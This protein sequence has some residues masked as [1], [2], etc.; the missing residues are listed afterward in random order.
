MTDASA[1]PSQVSQLGEARETES[2]A[3]TLPEMTFLH[4]RDPVRLF[5][6]RQRRIILSRQNGVC[7]G[8]NCGKVLQEGSVEFHHVIPHSLLGPTQAENGMALCIPCHAQADVLPL[9]NFVPRPWQ[10]AALDPIVQRLSLGQFATLA[11]APGAGKTAFTVQAAIGASRRAGIDHIVVLSPNAPLTGYWADAYGRAG[12]PIDAKPRGGR[13]A[14]GYVGLA[15][16]YQ[17]LSSPNTVAEVAAAVETH[18]SLVILDEAHHLAEDASGQQSRWAEAIRTI[19][20]TV[21]R[22]RAAVL[23]L[24]GTLFRSRPDQKIPTIAYRPVEGRADRVQAVADFTVSTGELID[25]GVLRHVDVYAFNAGLQ[26]VMPGSTVTSLDVIDLNDHGPQVRSAALASLLRDEEK[27][28]APMIDHAL[29]LIAEKTRELGSNVKGI[30]V[31]DDTSHADQV[32]AYLQRRLGRHALKAHSNT[33]DPGVVLD[34]FRNDPA[35]AILVTVRMVTEGFD[36]P[37]AAVLVVANRI[38]APLYVNQVSARVMRVS[39]AE[40]QKG[41]VL[42]ATILIPADQGMIDAYGAILNAGARTVELAQTCSIC[43]SSPCA[44]RPTPGNKQCAGCGMPWRLCVCLCPT[45]GGRALVCGCARVGNAGNFVTVTVTSDAEIA[46]ITHD[47]RSIDLN[48]WQNP[49]WEEHGLPQVY[50][51]AAIAALTDLADSQPVVL[52]SALLG[53][54]G[55]QSPTVPE[56]HVAGESPR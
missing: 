44:C 7:A 40:R 56:G 42:P 51:P 15:L 3:Y 46:Q 11:A 33:T 54:T 14:R 9:P 31:C 13:E 26:A 37:E 27:F 39:D 38:T 30:V 34:Q 25:A 52:A 55:S 8:S 22:P 21:Q 24:S 19:V 32:H 12:V 53:A 35:G 41:M 23:N 49:A 4:G 48:L 16:T 36:C 20:G 29:S 5:S 47:G 50:R 18:T 6:E 17:A 28:I 43:D 2:D 45:C 10:E 1:L